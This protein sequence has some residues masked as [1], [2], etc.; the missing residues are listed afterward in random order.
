VWGNPVQLTWSAAAPVRCSAALDA[1]YAVPDTTEDLSLGETLE[2]E[3]FRAWVRSGV[4]WRY[5]AD[6][7]L[8]LDARWSPAG[9]H[10]LDPAPPF[11]AAATITVPW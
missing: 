1:S 8:A 6:T 9:L 4:Q 3:R 7:V 11:Q 10:G 5:L 2:G